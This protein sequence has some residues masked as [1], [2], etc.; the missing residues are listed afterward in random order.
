MRGPSRRRYKNQ[1]TG[2]ILGGELFQQVNGLPERL[3][4]P[5]AFQ[6]LRHMPPCVF[7]FPVRELFENELGE[8]VFEMGH[9]SPSE[10]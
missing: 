2:D 4:L 3:D 6:A 1:T 9:R 5:L 10:L 8:T 7:H